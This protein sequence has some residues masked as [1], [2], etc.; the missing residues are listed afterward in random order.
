MVKDGTELVVDG[1][2]ID[3]Q[4]GFAMLVLVVHHLILPG[5]NLLGGDFTHFQF[6]EIGQQLGA[7][8]VVLG[9]PG[10]F[11]EPGLHIGCIA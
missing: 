2:E 8:D 9:G 7:D 4:I 5:D 3:W 11:L 6:A 1:L 10:I